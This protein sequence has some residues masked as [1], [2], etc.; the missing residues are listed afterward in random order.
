M[1]NGTA[2]P[3]GSTNY[4]WR[5]ISRMWILP[6]LQRSKLEGRGS[7]Y[8]ALQPTLAADRGSG[9]SRSSVSGDVMAAPR[10][11]RMILG[12]VLPPLLRAEVNSK[13]QYKQRRVSLH[14]LHCLNVITEI[15]VM[16]PTPE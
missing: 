9:R 8:T 12:L 6:S 5:W 1:S 3:L 11:R 15:Q 14:T 13:L 7:K 16:A 2:H 10:R 4:D